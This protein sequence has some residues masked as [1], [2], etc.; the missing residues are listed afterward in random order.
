MSSPELRVFASAPDD[1][2]KSEHAAIAKWVEEAHE[3]VPGELLKSQ[4]MTLKTRATGRVILTSNPPA[5]RLFVR[6]AIAQLKYYEG[7]RVRL[8]REALRQEL[9]PNNV[10]GVRTVAFQSHHIAVLLEELL[11]KKLPLIESDV[12]T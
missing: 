2:L 11:R 8:I 10:P 1:T 4:R 9:Y 12:M 5:Q 3:Y 7:E 6:A